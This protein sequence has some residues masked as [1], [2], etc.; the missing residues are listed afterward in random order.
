MKILLACLMCL[1]LSAAEC[2]AIKG[3]PDFGSGQV[4][5]TGTY[6]GIFVP[7]PTELDPGPPPVTLT[8]N[9][10]ALFTLKIPREGLATGTSA[11]FRNGLFYSGGITGSADPDSAKLTGIINSFFE[12]DVQSGTITVTK[13]YDANGQ[14]VNASIVANKNLF[15][16][17]A[18]RIRGKASITYRLGAN[19]TD[20]AAD[21]GGPIFYKIKGFKQ[22]EN[23]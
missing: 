10:L 19:A 16:T 6:A 1:V 2:F 18:S 11:V 3:G 9:S 13:H 15:S 23:S 5:V 8:D 22:S 7:I 17:A 14:F 20:P 12:E 21:S 4:G